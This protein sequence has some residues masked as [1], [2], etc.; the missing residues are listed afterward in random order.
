MI[1]LL[2]YGA[3]GHIISDNKTNTEIDIKKGQLVRSSIEGIN[4]GKR[5]YPGEKIGIFIDNKGL[6]T[7]D[8]NSEAG[9]FGTLGVIDVFK[10][11]MQNQCP[12]D[13]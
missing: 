11:F 5:G 12:L 6:G 9:I 7:I 2:K 10:M 13:F 8:I 4:R 1:Q 3:L